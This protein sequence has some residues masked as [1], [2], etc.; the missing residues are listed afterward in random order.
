MIDPT[1]MTAIE[2]TDRMAQQLPDLL[3][4]KLNREEDWK[5]WAWHVLQSPTISGRNPPN[6]ASFT[7]WR[8][9]AYRFNNAVF[10]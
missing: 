4:V 1:L 5:A 7:D 2:W 8:E 6:P 10:T 3:P 9:W